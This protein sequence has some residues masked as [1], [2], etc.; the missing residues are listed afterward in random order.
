[1]RKQLPFDEV[2]GWLRPNLSY[3]PGRSTEQ[4]PA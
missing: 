3:E 4:V 1:V 2:E